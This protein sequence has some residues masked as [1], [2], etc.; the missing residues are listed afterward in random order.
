MN[1]EKHVCCLCGDTF[2]G[3]GNNPDGALDANY[4]LIEWT[5]NDRCC[6]HCNATKVI[7]GRISL[8]ARQ[9]N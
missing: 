7:P 4:N 3:Y 8:I 5:P 2:T 9:R 1:K 6:D